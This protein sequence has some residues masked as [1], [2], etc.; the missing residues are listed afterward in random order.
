MYTTCSHP[1]ADLL[2]TV[3]FATQQVKLP[4]LI[5]LVIVFHSESAN[6]HAREVHV[7]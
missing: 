6:L 2:Q 5:R 1:H 4:S 7:V 3:H